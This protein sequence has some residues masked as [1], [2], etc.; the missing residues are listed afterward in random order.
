VSQ[1]A[2]AAATGIDKG[3]ISKFLSGQRAGFSPASLDA[4]GKYLRLTIA[5]AGPV[6]D[7]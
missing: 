2:I 1:Y 4:L 6:E 3:T 5:S 7:K